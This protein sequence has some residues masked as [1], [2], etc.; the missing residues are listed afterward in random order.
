M[1]RDFYTK[2]QRAAYNK[3]YRQAHLAHLRW[4]VR[5][6]NAKRKPK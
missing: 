5:L 2:A 6:C 4:L 3:K 1:N